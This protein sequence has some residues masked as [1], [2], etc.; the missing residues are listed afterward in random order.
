MIGLFRLRRLLLKRPEGPE[1]A[2]VVEDPLD[3]RHPEGPDELVLQIGD[4]HLEAQGL[5]IAAARHRAEPC[6][7]RPR[8]KTPV[9]AS[10]QSPTTRR[11]M[12]CGP[13]CSRN[14][15]TLV[16]PPMASTAMRSA[17]RSRPR[18]RAR[19]STA[20]RSLTPSTSTTARASPIDG[21]PEVVIVGA[22]RC[23]RWCPAARTVVIDIGTSIL[24]EAPVFYP[25]TVR[26]F[27]DRAEGVY[28]DRVAIVDEPDQPAPSLGELSYREMAANARAQAARLDQ[29]GVPVGGRV[30]VVS[31]NSA[32]LLTSFFGVSGL[33]TGAGADQLPAAVGRR[34]TTSSSIPVPTVLLVDPEL[35]DVLPNLHAKHRFVLGRTTTTS[36]CR[37]APSREP[38]DRP[39]RPR[40]PPSTTRAAP[41]PG[42]RACS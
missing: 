12:P 28:P 11:S 9:S 5:Q 1:V 21:P 13:Y 20:A 2:V 23:P 32:R 4:A 40:P 39:T 17:S 37:P 30:A 36:C 35:R 25:L 7:P 26:D 31:H 8:W 19:A 14:F 27:L 3:G 18:R 24:Q 15:R 33:G 16:A 42:P 6:A 34:S 29:L 38:W 41:P 10:S 22:Y